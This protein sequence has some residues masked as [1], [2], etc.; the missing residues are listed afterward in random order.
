ILAFDQDAERDR[1][2]Y[3]IN[4]SIDFLD[5]FSRLKNNYKS[6]KDASSVVQLF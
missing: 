4:L 5:V 1:L 3:L 6:S 2:M